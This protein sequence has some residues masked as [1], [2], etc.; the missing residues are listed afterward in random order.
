MDW[1]LPAGPVIREGWAG[2]IGVTAS[3]TAH[4]K[5]A[6]VQLTASTTRQ[7]TLSLTIGDTFASSA[8]SS[9][10]LDIGIGGAGSETVVLSNLEIGYLGTQSGATE[11][12]LPLRIPPGV[13]VAARIQAATASKV[14]YFAAAG[15][16]GRPE[17]GAQSCSLATPI[18]VSMGT[19]RG[20]TIT[21]SATAGTPGSWAQLTASTSTP[22]HELLLRVGGNGVTSMSNMSGRVDVGI[23]ESGSEVVLFGANIA[24][25]GGPIVSH[26][27]TSGLV[28][29]WAGIHIPA[30]TRIAARFTNSGSGAYSVDASAVLF[31]L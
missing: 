25:S 5:G 10:L 23:G 26:P 9:C 27:Q 13:R 16:G 30:G 7:S 14:V 11:F 6:W 29:P 19:S 21:S 1:P 15:W 24:L 12:L 20:T 3:G 2:W 31:T 18:G 8:D 28:I 17:A 22:T 4:T